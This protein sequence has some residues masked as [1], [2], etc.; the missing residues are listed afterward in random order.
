VIQIFTMPA[1]NPVWRLSRDS[2]FYNAGV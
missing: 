2:N 1:C